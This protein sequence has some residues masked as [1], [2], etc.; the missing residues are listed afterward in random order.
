MELACRLGLRVGLLNPLET[1]ICCVTRLEL[2]LFR[3]GRR[4]VLVFH[5]RRCLGLHHG[6][7][8]RQ[9]ALPWYVGQERCGWTLDLLAN[10]RDLRWRRKSALRR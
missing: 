8:Y 6:E 5:M 2:L 3:R 1:E 9:P 7:R 10:V 4:L